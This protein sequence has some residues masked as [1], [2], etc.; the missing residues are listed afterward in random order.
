MNSHILDKKL[1]ALEKAAQE[2]E[3]RKKLVAQTLSMHETELVRLCRTQLKRMNTVLSPLANVDAQTERQRA[4]DLIALLDAHLE[5]N[6][7]GK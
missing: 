1:L 6:Q 4:K 7:N 3:L 2:A 5:G